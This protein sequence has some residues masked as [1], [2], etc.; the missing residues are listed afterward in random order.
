MTSELRLSGHTRAY[1]VLGHPIG[2]SLSPA[3][4]NASL[5]RLGLDAV[6]LAFD[7]IPGK[8]A[9][10]LRALRD[11]GFGGVNVT[12]PH[13]EEALR[14]MDDLDPSAARVG[15]VNTVEFRPDGSLRGHNTDGRGFIRDLAEALKITPA[16]QSVFLLGAGGAGRALALTCAAAGARQITLADTDAA[17]AGRVR[18][19]LL[20]QTPGLAVELAPDAADARAATCRA[21]DLVLQATP[22]GMKRDDPA[23]LPPAAFRTGQCAYDLVYMY[24]ET[25]FMRAAATAGA[26]AANGLGMLLHQ[27]AEA[28]RIWTATE[29]DT[30][31][32]RAALEQA[33][34]GR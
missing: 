24:P 29:P 9:G 19:E 12:V 14:A 3:M 17:R 2:H 5:R 6:Y 28:F 34:Y 23:P 7:V 26:R 25:A 21:A 27:G 22:V 31:A 18:A 10:V 1:A 8:L 13:K 20:Q 11:L 16:G 4:H 30:A 32:M 15:A 33:V